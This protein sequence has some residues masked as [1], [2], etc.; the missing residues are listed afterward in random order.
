MKN[1]AKTLIKFGN[2]PPAAGIAALLLSSALTACGG[3][4][5]QNN[6]VITSNDDN[7]TGTTSACTVAGSYNF[8]D[9]C[10]ESDSFAQACDYAFGDLV[11]SSD[12]TTVCQKAS[13][14]ANIYGPSYSSAL[15]ITLSSS[16]F[17]RFSV[18]DD[19]A[20]GG[21][22]TGLTVE[23]G[24]KVSYRIDAGWSEITYSSKSWLGGLLNFSTVSTS[25][26]DVD[27]N[28]SGIHEDSSDND[29]GLYASDGTQLY[30]MPSSKDDFTIENSGTLSLGFNVETQGYYGNCGY[31][32][33]YKLQ[34]FHCEDEN[35]TAH[36]C[37]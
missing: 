34:V 23:A 6:V 8:F 24:D 21:Y 36:P 31:M 1:K 16:I 32:N 7:S 28:G 3:A 35:G 33:V 14:L 27:E 11:T 29:Q 2:L 19:D 13:T 18:V 22:S 5:P 17:P 15:S 4:Q 12:G 25:C 9:T 10:W 26:N 37:P 20:S 30:A